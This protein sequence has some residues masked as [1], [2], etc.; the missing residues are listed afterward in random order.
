MHYNSM[1]VLCQ[2]QDK[3]HVFV[4]VAKVRN[5]DLPEGKP[6]YRCS[7]RFVSLKYLVWQCPRSW[8]CRVAKL[9]I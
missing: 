3:R 7:D 2:A 1:F 6:W 4:H 5:C 8:H 9:P